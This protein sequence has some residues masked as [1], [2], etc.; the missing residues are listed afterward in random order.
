M[1]P[2]DGSRDPKSVSRLTI[3]RPPPR[4]MRAAAGVVIVRVKVRIIG[5]AWYATFRVRLLRRGGYTAGC[6]RSARIPA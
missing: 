5:T 2:A 4:T 6:A 3:G 1:I